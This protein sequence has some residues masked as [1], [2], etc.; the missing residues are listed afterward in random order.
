M[1]GAAGVLV[2]IAAALALAGCDRQAQDAVKHAG[3][4][5]KRDAKEAG[6]KAKHALK[7]VGETTGQVLEDTAIT[8]K[9]KAALH[10]EKDVRSRDIDIE[11]FQG[12]VVIKGT[13][14]DR[15]QA[16]R[17][18]TVAASVEG[19]KAVENRLAID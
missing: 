16:D 1:K 9:V 3:A 2:G 7:E 14:P 8:A 5:I 19:V 6:A 15:T 4:E 13:V 18:A 11:T 12:K 10:A 17:A